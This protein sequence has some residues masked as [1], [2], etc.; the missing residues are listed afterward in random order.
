MI[1]QSL[2]GPRKSRCDILM[3]PPEDGIPHVNKLLVCIA[4][5]SVVVS[6]V[7]GTHPLIKLLYLYFTKKMFHLSFATNIVDNLLFATRLIFSH[8]CCL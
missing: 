1:F 6:V 5:A 3:V 8:K 7:L 4:V 2:M